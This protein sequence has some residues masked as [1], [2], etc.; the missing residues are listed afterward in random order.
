[1]FSIKGESMILNNK[2]KVTIVGLDH[3]GRGIGKIFD[4]TI[5]IPNALVGETVEFNLTTIKKK[6]LEGELITIIN[7]S[8]ER[9]K[10]ICPY[11]SECGG[12]DL[13][14]TS[15]FNQLDYKQHKIKE[16]FSKFTTIDTSIIDNIVPCDDIY[17]YRNKV[18]LQVNDKIGFYKKKTNEIVRIN[19]CL[20]SDDVINNI[21][22]ELNK[23]KPFDNIK[24][25]VIRASKFTNEMMIAIYT[26]GII[27]ETKIIE[28]L[29]EFVTSIVKYDNGYQ[30]LYGKPFITEKMNDLEFIISPSS[31][32]QVNTK[33]AIKLYDKVLEM[34]DLTG[35]EIIVD[36]YCG[37]GTI[38][39]YLSRYCQ[40]VI[41]VE[42]NEDA[43]SDAIKNK[44]LNNIDNI[45]FISGD[46]TKIINKLEVIP[47]IFVVDPPRSGLDDN[48][49]NNLKKYNPSKIIYVSCDPITLARDLE[50]LRESFDIKH[51]FPVD[52]FANT[53]HVECVSLLQRKNP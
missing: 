13:M 34:A 36:L 46:V 6:Y 39:L 20:I 45:E 37:T 25:I 2:Y 26:K 33:Q 32:F 31:F 42:V 38:G 52:M 14:H 10:P 4:K 53:Y 12:C 27:D 50:K 29:S 28:N 18:T 17:N 40:K 8:E 9:I 1:M 21:I 30:V 7:S 15:Y 47:D 35:K 23:L 5:F 48:I 44:E 11:F 24:Q 22:E 43:I 49:I 19:K 41:G 16:I 51:I 3:Q